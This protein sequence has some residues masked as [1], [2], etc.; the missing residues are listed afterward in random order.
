MNISSHESIYSGFGVAPSSTTTSTRKRSFFLFQS[1]VVLI[2]DGLNQ[3]K[4]E[5]YVLL[6]HHA[7]TFHPLNNLAMDAFQPPIANVKS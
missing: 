5:H 4:Q 2:R 6:L 7:R 3:L 1:R